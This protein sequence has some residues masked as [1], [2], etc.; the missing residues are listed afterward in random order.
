MALLAKSNCRCRG[1]KKLRRLCPNL[2]FLALNPYFMPSSVG[3]NTCCLATS[4]RRE[5]CRSQSPIA[6]SVARWVQHQ[7]FSILREYSNLP[8]QVDWFVS[9]KF[10]RVDDNPNNLD[11]IHPLFDAVLNDIRQNRAMEDQA[12]ENFFSRA[13][14]SEYVK[15]NSPTGLRFRMTLSASPQLQQHLLPCQHVRFRA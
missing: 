14:I 5:E 1:N 9:F 11:R 7:S 8:Q 3:P 2:E 12:R 15:S 4:G 13:N 6:R 10:L